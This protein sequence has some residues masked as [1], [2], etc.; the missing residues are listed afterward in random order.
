MALR[1][2]KKLI[3]LISAVAVAVTG[4]AVTFFA[5]PQANAVETGVWYKIISR[6]SGLALDVLDM[7]TEPGA[8][9]IQYNDTGAENQQFRFL[10]SG[11][12]Y[13]RIQA[14]HSG[15]VLDVWEWNAD[16]GATIAQ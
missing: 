12:G 1:L 16:N 3:L 14:R 8:E 7:S 11:G 4:A 15:Q 13:Y 2:R 10:D 6:H 9:I 5:M